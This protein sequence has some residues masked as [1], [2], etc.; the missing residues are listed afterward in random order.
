MR[1]QNVLQ[2]QQGR[3]YRQ[4]LQKKVSNEKRKVQKGSDN[5]NEKNKEGFG[6]D[7]E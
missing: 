4:R 6:K 1:D 3:T 5:E 7:L 2:M